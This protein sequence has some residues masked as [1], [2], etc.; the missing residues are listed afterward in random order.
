[1]SIKIHKEPAT[2]SRF[3]LENCCFC[4]RPT[5]FWTEGGQVA[6]C[7]RCAARG[8]PEDLPTKEE[9]IRRERIAD[10]S[11]SARPVPPPDLP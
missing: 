8:Y 10:H 9:W 3:E 1:M 6:C 5:P 7:E 2:V 11:Y 4:R